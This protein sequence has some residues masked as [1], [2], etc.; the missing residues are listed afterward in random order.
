MKFGVGIPFL[1]DPNARDPCQQTYALCQ[2]AEKAGFGFIS[3][4]HHVFTPD[5]VTSA[6]FV[7]LAAIAART[8]TI[9]L[10]SA[11]YLLPLHHPVAVAE[12]VATLDLLSGGRVIFG[13]GIGYR[14]YEYQGFGVSARDRGARADESMT[15][16]RSAWTTGRFNFQGK[17][18]NIPDLPA[19]PM[20]VRKPHPPMWV[21]GVSEAA[22]RRAARLGDGWISANMQMLEDEV[23]LAERYRTLCSLEEKQP[24]VC[25]TRDAWVAGTREEVVN[26]WYGSVVAR[27]LG[28]RRAGFVTSDPQGIY[29]RLELSEDV[30]LEEFARDRVIAGTPLDCI[31][32]IQHWRDRSACQSM[33]LQLNKKAGFEKLSATITMLGREVLPAFS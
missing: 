21:G 27:H 17:H 5:Y 30:S 20:P 22:I 10:A 6:P 33:L 29:A 31:S 32:Q 26:E 3:V 24:F 16:I 13:I 12:Q 18:F 7:I 28:Y 8:S 2:I 25:I 1:C 9:R 19:V 23:A 11:I 14:D 15:A 4:G